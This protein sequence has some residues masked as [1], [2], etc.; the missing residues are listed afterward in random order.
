V[1]TRLGFSPARGSTF[2]YFTFP[3]FDSIAQRSKERRQYQAAVNQEELRGAWFGY[4]DLRT[5]TPQQRWYQHKYQERAYIRVEQA[6]TRTPV[7][8]VKND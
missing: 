5:T 8:V 2:R 3:R 1:Y 6:H 4:S 7:F